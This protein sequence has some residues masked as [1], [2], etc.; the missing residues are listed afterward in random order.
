ML[1]VGWLLRDASYSTEI[2]Q[3][4]TISLLN[5]EGK[6]FRG[7]LAVRLTTFMLDNEYMN[8]SVQ[9]SG[10]P[11]VPGCLE[12]TSVTSKIIEHAKRNHG[13]LTLLWLDLINAY[14]TIP[15]K[16]VEATLKTYHILERLQTLLQCY[17]NNFNMSFTF[18]NFTTDW[19]KLELVSEIL[20][21]AAM[22]L[23]VKSAEKLRW[24]AVLASGIQQ[25]PIRA[26]M[27]NLTI[28][29]KSVPEGR[30]ILEHLV[31][32]TDWARME[33]KPVKSRSLVL[34][35]G[36]VQDCFRFKMGKDIIPTVQEK[37]LKSLGKWY[38]A[39][40]NDKQRPGEE[41]EHLPE[42]MAGSPLSSCS[43][44]LYST[45]S[46][47]PVTSVVEEYKATKTR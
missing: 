25:V 31:K 7:I 38:R 15:H 14:G 13:D 35:R 22:N 12:H 9:K 20:F 4:R 47:R 17:L 26:F 33:I 6:I 30:G 44:G 36:C 46:K 23:L 37:P 19:Q 5:M 3:F 2:K 16:L 43:I 40:L 42:E 27:D 45:G 24:G 18:G 32:L 10:V 29:A 39:D 21:S 41:D 34:R 11:G 8:T 1:M 28:T